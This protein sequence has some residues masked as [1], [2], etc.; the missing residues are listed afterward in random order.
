[1]AQVDVELVTERLIMRKWRPSDRGPFA[2]MGQDPRVMEYFPALLTPNESDELAARADGLFGRL[3]FGLWAL[4]RQDSGQFIGFTGLA[5]MPAGVPGSD[6][7][8]VG[9]RLAADHWGKGYATEAAR[10]ALDFGFDR[11]GLPRVNS[12][13]ALVNL[14]SQSVM[15]RLGMRRMDEF[16]HPRVVEGSRLRRHVRYVIEAPTSSA[17]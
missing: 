14:R 6:G 1:M 17:P 10:A 12:I 8:E 13:T 9:W 16:E 11:I 3:G 5:P 7:V 2:T 4:E 15:Q